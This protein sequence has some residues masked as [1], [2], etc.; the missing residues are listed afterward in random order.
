MSSLV[1]I[2]RALVYLYAAP[3]GGFAIFDELGPPWPK[4]EC[5]GYAPG[6]SIELKM[7]SA[8]LPRYDLPVPPSILSSCQEGEHLR[9]TVVAVTPDTAPSEGDATC[10]VDIFDGS[11]LYRKLIVKFLVPIGC[12]LEET[13]RELTDTASCY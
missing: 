9:G 12:C 5:Q 10:E 11:R 13:S 1:Q 6:N 4:H 7:P 2:L 8:C 3:N